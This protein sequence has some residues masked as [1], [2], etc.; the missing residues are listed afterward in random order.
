[1]TRP[2]TGRGPNDPDRPADRY[3]TE[4]LIVPLGPVPPPPDRPQ[5]TVKSVRAAGTP[6]PS[7]AAPGGGPA[8]S[9]GTAPTVIRSRVRYDSAGR[10]IG[11]Q[12]R[13][14]VPTAPDPS[15]RVARYLYDSENFRGEWR[16]H[17]IHVWP[18]WVSIALSPFVLGW[19]GGTAGQVS[20]PAARDSA[21]T[22]VG[23]LVV[24]WLVFLWWA[25][26]KLVDWW[27]DRLVLTNKR[28]MLVTGVVTRQV[29]MLPLARVTDMLYRQSVLG[30]ALNYGTFVVE[31]A[32]Q[33]QALR[34]V[35]NLPRPRQ[36]YLQMVEEMYAPE[37]AARRRERRR[38]EDGS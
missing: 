20:Q 35:K 10:P 31:S 9:G 15:K 27:Y 25:G 12:N 37:S 29:A 30:R 8:A 23:G 22:F 14:I 18:W 36:I 33:D 11:S 7:G 2:P 16:R 34:E 17:W 26:W 3:D 5:V 21:S 6:P 1:M 4:P 24:V 32:G 38:S 13:H 19:V 28:I